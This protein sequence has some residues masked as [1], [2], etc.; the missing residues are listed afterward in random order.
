MIYSTI[1]VFVQSQGWHAR[2]VFRIAGKKKLSA[3]IIDAFVSVTVFTDKKL[4]V[5]WSSLFAFG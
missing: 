3:S 5:Y 2:Q 4:A 1:F